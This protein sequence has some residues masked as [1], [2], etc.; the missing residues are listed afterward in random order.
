MNIAYLL[1]IT[2]LFLYSKK[3]LTNVLIYL[4]ALLMSYYISDTSEHF[5]TS[6]EA[7]QN[8]ASIYNSNQ[9]TVGN[10][11]VTNTLTT[12]SAIITSANI[13]D[14]LTAKS[15]KCNSASVN[16]NISVVSPDSDIY[17][18]G[19]DRKD[20]DGRA[21]SWRLWHMNKGYGQND[22]QIWQ[23]KEGTDG[24]S[25]GSTAGGF[26][27]VRMSIKGNGDVMAHN[28]LYALQN[29]SVN[30]NFIRYAPIY[31]KH[32]VAGYLRVLAN[33]YKVPLYYGWNILWANTDIIR[34]IRLFAGSQGKINYANIDTR[35][36]DNDDWRARYFVLFPGYTARFFYFFTPSDDANDFF[37][38]G[39]YEWERG[40]T[41]PNANANVHVIYVGLVEEPPIAERRPV[42]TW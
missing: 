21:N 39:E 22:L 1:I 32:D 36:G 40:R 3:T 38:T 6:N 35:Q 28:D 13:S 20:E 17:S 4:V 9:L 2:L 7:V 42:R 15:I 16:G 30:G 19:F 18:L 11:N 41:G 10:A 29:M 26:C 8:I 33:G 25:C 37:Q 5:T 23:Y 12:N 31:R 27:G 14:S 24:K 34:K